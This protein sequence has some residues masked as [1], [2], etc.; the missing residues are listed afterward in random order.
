MKSILQ[1]IWQFILQIILVIFL[2]I[3]EL[4][5]PVRKWFKRTFR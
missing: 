5:I 2:A 4:S 1:F 3:N